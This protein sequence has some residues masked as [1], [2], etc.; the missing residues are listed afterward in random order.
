MICLLYLQILISLHHW[1]AALEQSC[2]TVR[3]SLFS[4]ES[5]EN[6]FIA[7]REWRRLLPLYV[8]ELAV[9][10]PAG[11]SLFNVL[12]PIGPPCSKGLKLFGDSS[13]A[14]VKHS[15]GLES[16]EKENNC[17]ILNIGS[18]DSTWSFEKAMF[19]NIL[20]SFIIISMVHYKCVFLL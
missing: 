6:S 12:G 20:L 18:Y 7:H 4:T 17:N 8:E 10:Y 9:R 1:T 5:L 2:S 13:S 14:H 15:C 16:V 11:H 19:G 3:T